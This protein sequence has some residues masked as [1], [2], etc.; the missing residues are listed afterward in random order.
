MT[1]QSKSIWLQG[2]S[3]PQRQDTPEQA[4]INRRVLQI[5][6]ENDGYGIREAVAKL[7]EEMQRKLTE[8][9]RDT[10]EMYFFAMLYDR[11]T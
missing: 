4:Q 1:D 5:R 6:D 2:P 10:A 8:E 11:F 7:E 3:V 9:E